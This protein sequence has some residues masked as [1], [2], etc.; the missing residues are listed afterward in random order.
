[1][2]ELKRVSL[3]PLGIKRLD[4]FG[5]KLSWRLLGEI[6]LTCPYR[7]L[8]FHPRPEI[9]SSHFTPIG[10]VSVLAPPHFVFRPRLYTFGVQG[11]DVLIRTRDIIAD[12]LSM[13]RFYKAMPR[14]MQG[15]KSHQI[16]SITVYSLKIAGL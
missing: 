12:A 9:W 11:R 4:Q 14:Q 10:V 7:F 16:K 6:Y 15:V 5:W 3:A 2:V 13:K 8:N 1:V